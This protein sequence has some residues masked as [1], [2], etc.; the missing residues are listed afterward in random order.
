MYKKV[1]LDAN[2]FIDVNDKKRVSYEESFKII[3]YL[4]INEVEIY[5]SCDLITTIYYILSK[6]D[7]LNALYKIDEINDFCKIIEFSNQEVKQTCELMKTNPKYKD[8]E[9]TIQ[10]ILAK[11]EGCDLIISNDKE[12]ISDDIELLTTAKFI[13][14]LNIV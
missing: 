4:L 1:F 6:N 9:D 12:F 11:K 8:L 14:K 5:T 13:E 2:I 7:K 10:Y 3:S